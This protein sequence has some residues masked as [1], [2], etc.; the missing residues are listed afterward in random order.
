MGLYTYKGGVRE[1][2]ISIDF[3]FS[4]KANFAL[5]LGELLPP[6]SWED[7]CRCLWLKPATPRVAGD[8]RLSFAHRHQKLF[9]CRQ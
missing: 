5:I 3:F 2:S 9:K 7:Y 4:F 1:E 6:P 8:P